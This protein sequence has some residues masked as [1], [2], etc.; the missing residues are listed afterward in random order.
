[1]AHRL[2]ASLPISMAFLSHAPGG[3]AAQLTGT[4]TRTPQFA[5][6]MVSND[7]QY[8][9]GQAYSDLPTFL[10]C[11][12]IQ[13]AIP[14]DGPVAFMDAAGATALRG[15]SG[16]AG[17]AAVHWL[18]DQYYLAYLKNGSAQQQWAFQFA[19][20]EIGNDY[21]GNVN[22]IDPAV[23]QSRP[24]T[25][26]FFDADPT[27][28]AA[29][30]TMYQ[31][32]VAALPTLPTTY[33]SAQFTLD[34]FRN[35]DPLLQDMVALVERAPPPAPPRAIPTLGSWSTLMLSALLCGAVWRHR[36]NRRNRAA[37]GA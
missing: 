35:N 20:W 34:L 9:G 32:L 17:I 1:M 33:R 3:A 14:P 12:D 27:Y 7:L 2:L 23:G 6:A 24:V 13:T 5:L 36:R 4:A 22:T 29:Y 8:A 10:V 37:R 25:G 11:V 28:I 30:Q 15:G 16:A 21:N 26:G 18:F 31:G 19:V